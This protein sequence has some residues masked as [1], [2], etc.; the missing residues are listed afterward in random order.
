MVAR[1]GKL[2]ATKC[3]QRA[4][5]KCAKYESS[6]AADG[7]DFKAFVVESH[8]WLHSSAVEVVQ[9]LAKNAAAV[10]G[11]RALQSQM[12]GY[13]RRRLAVAVARGAAWM[14][15]NVRQ[16]SRGC[17]GARVAS[18]VVESAVDVMAMDVA[19]VVVEEDRNQPL[20]RV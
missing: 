13:L 2:T 16:R 4:F 20:R 1:I 9:E 11:G 3:G 10:Y 8:G 18:G 7:V 14:A 12:E 19:A 17:W 5:S 6:C 15:R